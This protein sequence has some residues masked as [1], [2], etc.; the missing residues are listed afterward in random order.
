MANSAINI[1]NVKVA[2]SDLADGIQGEFITW[3][4][5]GSPTTT[6]ITGTGIT[7]NSIAGTTQTAVVRNGYVVANASQTTVTLPAVAALGSVVIVQGLGAGGWILQAAAGDTIKIGNQ[8]TSSGGT[9]TS[10][11]QW[12]AIEVVCVVADT[13]WSTRSVVS[14]GLTYA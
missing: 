5:G 4:G 10:T 8:T 9:L 2:I 13:T 6:T 7:W 1:G 11:N 3:D 12:D 14:S